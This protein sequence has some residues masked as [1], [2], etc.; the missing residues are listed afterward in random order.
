MP[1][2]IVELVDAEIVVSVEGA[3]L[4]EPLV[5][6][7]T[8]AATLSQAW[9]ESATAPAGG[10][11]KSSKTW[12]GE[13]E[14]S[15]N[16]AAQARDAALA[17]ANYYPT[18]S[19]GVAATAVD[20][21]F[22]SDESGW[23]WY[24]RTAS[25]PFYTLLTNAFT[26]PVITVA[27]TGTRAAR[28]AD[29]LCDGTADQVQINAAIA[30]SNAAGG[31]KVFVANGVYGTSQPIVMQDNVWLELEAAAII[32]PSVGWTSI[33]DATAH[34]SATAKS[35]VIVTGGIIDCVTNNISGNGLEFRPD[36]A[37]A[38]TPCTN[39]IVSGVEVRMKKGIHN[40]GIWSMRAVGVR[41]LNNIVKGG[42][43]DADT[44]TGT[45]QQEGIEAY[46][47]RDVLIQGNR[48][49]GIGGAA[50]NILGAT[51]T[52]AT[53]MDSI[54]VIDNYVNIT[55]RGVQ[56]ILTS[57]TTNG[58]GGLRNSTI[59][60]NRLTGVKV[61][62]IDTQFVS[63]A[64]NGAA[65]TY[66]RNKV[67]DNIIE[68]SATGQVST[69]RGIFFNNQR[70][71]SADIDAYGNSAD[72]NTISNVLNTDFGGKVTFTRMRGFSFCGNS[73]VA[74]VQ[75]S[76]NSR[77]LLLLLCS[78]FS[79]TD[80]LIDGARDNCVEVLGC[81][82]GKVSY[83][84]LLNWNSRAGGSAG[85]ICNSSGGNHSVDLQIIE[86]RF[87]ATT[88]TSIA[89]MIDIVAASLRIEF[90]RNAYMG[91]AWTGTIARYAGTS[92]PASMR[93]VTLSPDD[94]TIVADFGKQ[95]NFE[96]AL[97]ATRIL[98]NPINARPGQE[99]FF[100]I[101]QDATGSRVLTYGN[102]WRFPGGA[103]TGGVL[104]TAANSVDCIDYRVGSDG[105]I[106]ANLTKAFAA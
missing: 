92:W 16:G 49:L 103:A 36:G 13:S 42:Y 38:G 102:N 3:E 85:L 67:D 106:Y 24:R 91:S 68:M 23:A 45:E 54:V 80:N 5:T 96:L 40:Y 12:A 84:T 63:D 1:I 35:N 44:W 87:R 52:T 22:I 97:N 73:S 33:S 18:I 17:A 94:A 15:A 9:A 86:N 2:A 98:G 90:D 83:N 48:C 60:N 58:M 65:I 72:G 30:A 105:K 7:A 14:G 43:T 27:R 59:R 29:Y 77:G 64:N 8:N 88:L 71:T 104:S 57:H 56:T 51:S 55:G 6:T 81:V 53:D 47:G 75:A 66:N 21:V 31:G 37:F 39:I 76:G 89:T 61:I 93:P 101:T 78:D 46:G 82:S 95:S 74:P 28:H 99:G 50:L 11:T 4:L 10:S 41:I 19:G 32:R 34:I 79:A 62:G 26:A 70:A 100:R 25:G 20:G 69:A